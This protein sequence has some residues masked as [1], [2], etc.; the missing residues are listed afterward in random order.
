MQTRPNRLWLAVI[1]LGWAFDL[2]FWKQAP[3]ISFAIYVVLTLATG[4]LLLGLDRVRP[5]RAAVALMLPIALFALITFNRAEPLTIFLAHAFALFL[6]VL[7]VVTFIGG[8]WFLYSVA[9][10]V[11]NLTKLLGSMASQPVIFRNETKGSQPETATRTDRKPN[12]IWPIVRGVLIAIPVIVVFAALLSSADLVFAERLGR[13]VDI[14]R[15]EKLPEYIFRL[16][17]ILVIAYALAGVYLHAARKSTDATLLGQEKPLVAP[18][19]GF[20]EAAIVL[21][22]LVALFAAFVIVQVQYFF[23]AQANITAAGYTYAEYARR[24]FG[25]LVAVASF[26]LLLFLGLSAITRRDTARQ[27]NIFA[28]LGVALTA[29][30][31]VI[32]LSAYD[33][34]ALYEAA[35][36]FTRLRAYTNV[37]LVWVGA[38]LLAVV[39]LDLLKRQRM[40]AFAALM[41]AVG[42][43]LSIGLVNVDAFI[44]EHNIQRGIA[45]YDLDAGYLASLSTDAVPVMTEYYV[46]SRVDRV[47]RE[48]VGAA[49]ACISAREDFL[50]RP[51]AWQSINLSPWRASQ[52]IT[53]I[54]G[55]LNA[56]FKVEGGEVVAPGGETYPCYSS[57]GD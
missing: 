19:L 39:V 5:A 34:L 12:R 29:L 50:Y 40:F 22:S 54:F 56:A 11:V 43:G 55:K 37:L 47:T 24:G 31:G 53:P 28:A 36:G 44:A 25:E 35:Y 30:V 48:S 42:F 33:R 14:F 23:G 38:L 8:R 57:S 17:Y 18:F 45:G 7:L 4:F 51:P 21:G 49:L 52:A 15:L 1:A 20:T 2:L 10:Y 16:M 46:A 13:L 26:S 41:A 9:D 27:H 6:M 32:L 3:G